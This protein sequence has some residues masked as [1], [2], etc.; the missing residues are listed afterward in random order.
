MTHGEWEKRLRDKERELLAE[1]AGTADE[2][3]TAAGMETQDSGAA[4]EGKENL[5]EETSAEWNLFSD[6]RDALER[7]RLGTFGKCT[8]CGQAIEE[9]RLDAVPWTAYCLHHERLH[10]RD[11]AEHSTA[12]ARPALQ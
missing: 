1:R 6:V 4:A 5:L 11:L 9:E 10:E 12:A 7:I 3:R 2:A 8:E